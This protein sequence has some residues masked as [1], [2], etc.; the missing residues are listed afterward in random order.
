[1][2]FQT[3]AYSGKTCLKKVVLFA[4]IAL[5]SASYGCVQ[6][7][8][9]VHKIVPEQL[10]WQHPDSAL[11]ILNSYNVEK[12]DKS[13][14][15]TYHLDKIKASLRVGVSVLP[16]SIIPLFRYFQEKKLR[17][18][19]GEA[20]YA[21]F[22]AYN[23]QQQY[24]SSM[25]MLKEAEIYL[26]FMDSI[27][28]GMVYY[29]EGVLAEREQLF[30]IASERYQK[31]LPFIRQS[32]DSLRIA[33]CLRDAARMQISDTALRASLFGEAL[34]IAKSI[35]HPILYDDILVQQS[36]YCLPMDSDVVFEVSKY[37]C[38]SFRLSR[39]ANMVC[40]IAMERG[41]LPTAEN[42]FSLLEND[43]IHYDI[44]RYIYYLLR[45]K[46]L[47]ARGEQ[48][49]AYSSLEKAYLRVLTDEQQNEAARTYAI[50]RHYDVE[51]EQKHIL[52]LKLKQQQF[53]LTT[54]MI[55]TGLLLA[56]L[57]VFLIYLYERNKR[58]SKEKESALQQLTIREKEQ[59]IAEKNLQQLQMA[60]ELQK[61]QAELEDKRN[62]LRQFLKH[63]IALIRQIHQSLLGS[64]Q[65]SQSVK[66]VLDEL[67]LQHPPTWQKFEEEFKAAY[68]DILNTIRAKYPS[69]NEHDI[70][71]IALSIL[72]I[73]PAEMACVF[74]MAS[75]SVW[76]RRDRL[77][78]H[79][80]NPNLDFE[81]WIQSLREKK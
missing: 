48:Q 65:K 1:M 58:I 9:K 19:S 61:A 32:N 38:D 49:E 35:N 42:Y 52:E 67:S 14:L 74:Q 64:K 23:K 56:C 59:E 70:R 29:H 8:D 31:A 11:L 73:T 26:P 69:L 60:T 17:Q 44:S 46:M 78:K 45:S 36:M 39:Y 30:H 80:G 50:S 54:G 41:D 24:D 51:K 40:A 4:A 62:T 13:Q 63:R 20:A 10:I 47:Q 7:Q 18:Q 15:Q 79:L 66:K 2:R 22:I 77:K 68:G 16:D 43:T 71:Y 25:Y 21:L 6:K 33:C 81:E 72:E 3:I 53:W 75:Q 76:N 37:L 55:I 28:S 34:R 5:L 12:L 57:C 27:Y